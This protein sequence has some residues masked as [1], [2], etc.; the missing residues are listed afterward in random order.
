MKVNVDRDRKQLTEGLGEAVLEIRHDAGLSVTASTPF[1][2]DVY[3]D[4]ELSDRQ[5]QVVELPLQDIKES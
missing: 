2:G 4:T 5:R 1:V 3:F